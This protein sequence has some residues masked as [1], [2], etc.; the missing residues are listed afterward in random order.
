MFQF[1]SRRA[2]QM[3]DRF[4]LPARFDSASVQAFTDAVKK[5]RKQPLEIDGGRVATTGALAI[6]ALISTARQWR[7]DEAR[8]HLAA[9]SDALLDACRVLGVPPEEI[10]IHPEEGGSA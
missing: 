2:P 10:G 5:L 4:S 7:E 1:L 6:Q 3:E 9:P 8:F